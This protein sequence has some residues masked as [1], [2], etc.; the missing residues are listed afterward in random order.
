MAKTKRGVRKPQSTIGRAIDLETIVPQPISIEIIYDEKEWG[1]T[2]ARRKAEQRSLRTG[3]PEVLQ[4]VP[5]ARKVP[6]LLITH[7]A[8]WQAE[9][10]FVLAQALRDI[11]KEHRVSGE[12]YFEVGETDDLIEG[13]IDFCIKFLATYGMD[14]ERAVREVPCVNPADPRAIW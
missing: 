9:H 5:V 12:L 13:T 10:R 4:T 6:V 8:T 7:P 14:A 1:S 11:L 2:K 3:E